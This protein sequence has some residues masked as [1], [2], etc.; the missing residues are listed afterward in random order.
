MNRDF[1]SAVAAGKLSIRC[2]ESAVVKLV[3]F[4]ALSPLSAKVLGIDSDLN[5]TL[6][7]SPL[8]RV[9]AWAYQT[10][11]GHPCFST[12]G[13][14]IYVKVGSIPE[15]AAWRHVWKNRLTPE[16]TIQQGQVIVKFSYEVS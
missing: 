4:N 1:L 3:A 6:S 10:F 16:I 7:V 14:H 12:A 15:V 13:G 9:L 2:D 5:I 8:G 11:I